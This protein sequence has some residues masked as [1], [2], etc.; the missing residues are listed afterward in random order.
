MNKEENHL[1]KEQDYKILVS[2]SVGKGHPVKMT[3]LL[4]QF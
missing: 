3:K 4:M 1:I 2:E